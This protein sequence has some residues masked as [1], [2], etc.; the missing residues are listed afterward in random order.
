MAKYS[1]PKKELAKDN[2]NG[3]QQ[4]VTY[5]L[6]MMTSIFVFIILAVY[7][8][9]YHNK[10]FDMGDSKFAFFQTVSFVFL[11]SLLVGAIMWIIANYKNESFIT[12]IKNFSITDWMALAYLIVCYVSFLFCDDKKMAFDGFAGWNMGLVSQAIFV[13]MYFFVSRCWRWSP[14]TLIAGLIAAFIAYFLAVIMRFGFDPLGMY[15]N[16]S[17]VD[18]EKFVSTLGQTTWYSSYAVLI[19]PLGVYYYINDDKKWIKIFSS[20][21][22]L[23]GSMSLCTTN[24]DSAYIAYLFI[25]LVF[26]CFSFESNKKFIKFLDVAVILLF[27]CRLIGILQDMFPQRQVVLVTGEEK[28]SKFVTHNIVMLILLIFVLV[29]DIVLRYLQKKDEESGKNS[30]TIDISKFKFLRQIVVGIVIVGIWAVSMLI[31][32]TTKHRLPEFLNKLYSIDFF[33]FN[34]AWGNCRGFNWTAAVVAFKSGNIKD[35][36]IGVGPDCFDV[37]MTKY[38]AA[39]VA[40]FWQGL[41]LACAHNEFL[42]LLVTSGILGLVSYLGMMISSAVRC[43]KLAIKEPAAVFVVAVIL[44]Y[45]GH[46]FFCYQQCICTPYLFI[47]IGMGEVII[48]ETKKANK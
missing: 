28:I 46:N 29:L 44:S 11:G 27:A 22:I 14:T 12:I 10:Y 43:A 9:F 48:K 38:Y 37:A 19:F 33:I 30:Q 1:K 5:Y 23:L 3:F 41:H 18:I 26:F 6:E 7:P 36:L 42:N 13:L 8:L 16:L 39:E 17:L 47:F 25:M 40:R 34:E 4:F 24:S 15:E 32:L 35:M 31:I 21:F 2:R 45:I 20:I